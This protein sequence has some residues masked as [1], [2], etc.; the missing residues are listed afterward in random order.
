MPKGGDW[1]TTQ[2]E[3]AVSRSHLAWP[4]R[5]AAFSGV[6]GGDA[7]AAYLREVAEFEQGVLY[8]CGPAQVGFGVGYPPFIASPFLLEVN[9][10]PSHCG[11]RAPSGG[12][13]ECVVY[14]VSIS[15]GLT[16]PGY[17]MSPPPGAAKSALSI[18]CRYLFRA[19]KPGSLR[20]RA[21][22]CRPP[23]GAATSALLISCR[24]LFRA[25]K[26]G[27]YA[28]GLYD[29]A[30]L[31][32]LG[33]L[34]FASLLTPHEGRTA[35][36]RRSPSDL[37]SSA[38]LLSEHPRKEGGACPLPSSGFIGNLALRAPS[39]GKRCVSSPVLPSSLTF[40]SVRLESLT[41]EEIALSSHV[42]GR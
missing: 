4:L 29:V 10:V 32:G 20:H 8:G 35:G 3:N 33:T 2:A 15:P 19:D 6:P 14:F 17:T 38:I 26:P 27:A 16:P 37:A 18:S 9:L 28:A 34:S 23:P 39:K 40:R 21:I 24:Y 25:D 30:P 13:D 41:Y 22:R 31:R 5:H 36:L 12:C 42:S 7:L 1:R 11:S